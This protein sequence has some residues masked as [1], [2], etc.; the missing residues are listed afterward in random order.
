[1]NW[2]RRKF[3]EF[4]RI[5]HGYAFKS[6]YYA[7][8]GKYV[9]L[10][11]GNFQEEG[12]FRD[13]NNK[14]KFYVGTIP[15]DYVLKRGDLLVAM[16]EQA[17]G[18]LGSAV[19]IPE[20]N[21]YLHNQR[22]GLI[23]E[24]DEHL[25]SKEFLYHLFNSPEVRLQIHV[26]AG[27]TKVR[28]T[29]P[30]KILA[31]RFLCPPLNIQKKIAEVISTWDNT[32]EQT[33]KLI[34]ARVKRKRG[35]MQ[36]LLTGKKRFQEFQGQEW[37]KVSAGEIFKSISV[38]GN[39]NEELLSATQDKGIIPRRML[40][41]RVTMPMGDT[42]SFKLVEVGDFVISLRSFQGGLEY[43]YYRGIVSPA[44]TVL[45]PKKI[46]NAEF[47]KQYF[48]SYEFIGR[49]ATA[50]IG[51]RDGKQVSYEDYC[52]VK[53]PFPSIEEQ[54]R[55]AQVLNACDKEIDLLKQQLD[56]LKQQKRGL[57]KKLLTGQIRVKVDDV[58]AATVEAS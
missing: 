6:E 57:M 27:G 3:G 9:L 34:S 42:N 2:E 35:L 58:E 54:E 40:E 50:V 44:Y 5:K 29:S 10:T 33:K 38:K 8:E 4:F 25:L 53:I 55:I 31:V 28:H 46:I 21:R 17:P 12:G 16:T 24:L 22:L 11:P 43:S 41:A 18:L 39:E 19:L 49:L 52:L 36:Q 13:R 26:G 15:N 47:Y 51:I 20:G 7:N 32:I 1:M 37:A 23:V 48:K 45:K 30:E 56:A 14:E